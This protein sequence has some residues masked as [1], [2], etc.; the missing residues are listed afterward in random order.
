MK[1]RTHI[2]HRVIDSFGKDEK[3]HKK[4]KWCCTSNIEKC[5]QL[6]YLNVS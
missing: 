5:N 2:N 4:G 6:K 3:N 1:E